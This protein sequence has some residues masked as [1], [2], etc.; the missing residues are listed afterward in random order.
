MVSE[1]QTLA[2]SHGGGL[3]HII[4]RGNIIH[5]YPVYNP[6]SSPA[7]TIKATIEGGNTGG[8]VWNLH[9]IASNIITPSFLGVIEQRI[10]L[11]FESGNFFLTIQAHQPHLHTINR[12]HLLMAIFDKIFS[13]L[14][15][16][17]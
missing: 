15:A 3:E 4:T 9:V 7:V 1:G 8:I 2:N 10:L 12:C 13:T 16:S 5:A 6:S 11:N 14:V 17:V